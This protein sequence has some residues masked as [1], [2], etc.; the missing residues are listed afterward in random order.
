[1]LDFRREQDTWD[2]KLFID[3]LTSL[4][5]ERDALQ[6]K[7]NLI[8]RALSSETAI[9]GNEVELGIW[10]CASCFGCLIQ[11]RKWETDVVPYVYSHYQEQYLCLSS[12]QENNLEQIDY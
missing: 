12:S 1:M 9:W 5:S 2:L 11:K 6:K 7:T 3:N 8:N 4:K 10:A